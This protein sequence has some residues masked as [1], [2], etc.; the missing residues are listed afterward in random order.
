MEKRKKNTII[1]KLI[2]IYKYSKNITPKRKKNSYENFVN[3]C[4]QRGI[5]ATVLNSDIVVSEFEF[6]ARYYVHFQINTYEKGMNSLIPQLSVNS[7]STVF[8]QG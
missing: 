7:I 4:I 5:V 2:K 6:Q 1:L 8:L 3:L